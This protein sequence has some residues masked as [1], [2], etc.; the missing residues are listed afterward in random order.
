MYT[1]LL[2]DG[3]E[4]DDIL[5]LQLRH[6]VELALPSNVLA[7]ADARTEHLAGDQLPTPLPWRPRRT[8]ITDTDMIAGRLYLYLYLYLRYTLRDQ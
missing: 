6:H 2:F 7:W 4:L 8:E 5:V 3:D 1:Y